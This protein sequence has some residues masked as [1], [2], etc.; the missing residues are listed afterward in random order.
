MDTASFYELDQEAE[1][2]GSIR[3]NNRYLIWKYGVP[4]NELCCGYCTHYQPGPFSWGLC[5]YNNYGVK[6][7]DGMTNWEGTHACKKFVKRAG[8]S[9]PAKPIL[10]TVEPR[11]QLAFDF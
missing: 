7:A 11:G 6:N 8:E 1:N 10:L 2:C 4:Y 5:L 3:V 9:I